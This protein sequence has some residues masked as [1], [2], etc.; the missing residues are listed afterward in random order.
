MTSLRAVGLVL[1]GAVLVLGCDKDQSF[2]AKERS[3]EEL[4][5]RTEGEGDASGDVEVGTVGAKQRIG[6]SVTDEAAL[7]EALGLVADCL[8]ELQVGQTLECD[9]STASGD[10]GVTF[11]LADAPEGMSLDPTSG[12]LTWTPRADQVGPVQLSIV[13]MRGSANAVGAMDLSVVA[14]AVPVIEEMAKLSQVPLDGKVT[15]E[16]GTMGSIVN[17]EFSVTGTVSGLLIL[18]MVSR[19]L[20]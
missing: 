4:E 5:V 20:T 14:N 1:L 10:D 8:T 6:I 19:P 3:G 16:T 13:T 11:A 7:R 9:L 18:P 2:V 12:K 17:R 15:F